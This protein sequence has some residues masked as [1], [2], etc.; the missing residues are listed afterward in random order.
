VYLKAAGAWQM[1]TNIVGPQG[2]QG[3]QGPIGLTGV[4]GPQGQIGPQGIKGDRGDIGPIGL[5]GSFP[6]GTAPGDI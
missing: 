2:I 1:I 4:Q 3:E 6:S 5:T